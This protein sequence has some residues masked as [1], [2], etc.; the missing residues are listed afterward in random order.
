[1]VIHFCRTMWRLL[2]LVNYE[3]FLAPFP[4]S[5][6]CIE[7]DIWIHLGTHISNTREAKGFA[8]LSEEG[9]AKGIRRITAVT[10]DCAFKAMELAYSLEQEVND[11]SKIEASLLEK[12]F[13]SPSVPSLL[14][15]VTCSHL[16]SAPPYYF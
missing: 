12:V 7:F 14:A 16:F 6:C 4:C 8:L 15:F 11:A 1:M 3:P 5:E 10:T 2:S 13:F 9:I